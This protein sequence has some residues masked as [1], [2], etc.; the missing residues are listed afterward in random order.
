MCI[1]TW[2]SLHVGEQAYHIARITYNATSPPPAHTHDFVEILLVESGN[3]IHLVNGVEQ[4]LRA[5]DLVFVRADDHHTFRV[6]RGGMFTYV[7]LA[8]P[9]STA[10]FIHERYFPGESSFFRATGVLPACIS[11]NAEQLSALGDATN[12]LPTTP[13]TRLTLE[14]YLINLCY[15]LTTPMTTVDAQHFPVWIRELCQS[16]NDP[17]VLLEGVPALVHVAQRSAEHIAREVKRWTGST[18]TQLVNAARLNQAAARLCMSDDTILQ[19]ALE[20]GFGNLSHFY[21]CFRAKFAQTPRQ[22]RVHHKK[23]V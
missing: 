17:A 10:T 2:K 6:I 4:P 22:Y 23:I 19:I 7:N 13:H 14:R 21:T 20:T 18:P 5:G 11:A 8:F 16:L 15:T 12:D 9:M 3:G 1:I